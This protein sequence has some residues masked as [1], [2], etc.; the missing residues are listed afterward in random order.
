MGH[1][2]NKR[3]ALRHHLVSAKIQIRRART[4]DAVAGAALHGVLVEFRSNSHP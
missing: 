2:H 3:R 1:C 4:D